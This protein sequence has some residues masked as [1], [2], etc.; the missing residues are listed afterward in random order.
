MFSIIIPTWNNLAFVQCCVQSILDNSIYTHQIILHI[1]DGSDGTLQWAKD[2]NILHTSSQTNI[3]ICNAVNNASALASSNYIMYM[4]DDMYCLP[5]WDKFLVQEIEKITDNFFML[6]ATMIEPLDTN[7]NCVIVKN[8][9]QHP[10]EFQREQL[11]QYAKTITKQNWSG[12]FWPP[13]VVPISLWKAIG[14]F[15]T[16]FSPG[17]SSD[18]DF[19]HKCWQ[20]GCRIF[21]GVGKSLVYHFQGKSTQRVAKNNGRK[22]YLQKYGITQGSFRNYYLQLG[23]PPNMP[24]LPPNKG[25]ILWLKV[26]GFCKNILE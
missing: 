2:N 23:N 4:N 24:L 13:N 25:L 7:N 20:Q 14:G 6:S 16:A 3:G 10:V 15:S 1:N 26:K 5:E 9:G 11:L 12:S 17:M 8:F 21:M 18:D 22:Q 19:V